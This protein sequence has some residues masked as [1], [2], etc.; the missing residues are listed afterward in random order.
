MKRLCIVTPNHS[1]ASMG[2]AEYQID[3][4]L[5]VMTRT[6]ERDIYYL[7]HRVPLGLKANGYRIVQVGSSD[8]VGRFG[9][10]LD[11]A[12]LYR[13]LRRI[14]PDVIYQRV[15]CG[16][17]G[18]AAHYAR[19]SGAR[20]VWH[21][22]HDSDVMPRSEPTDA[23]N[24]IKRVFEK[25][26]VEYGIRHAHR[27][28]VQTERQAQLLNENFGRKAD[29]LI[30]NFH[31]QPRESVEKPEPLTVV[32]I[33]NIKRW[34]QPEAFIRLAQ[35][36]SDIKNVRFVMVGALD[37]EGRTWQNDLSHRLA[38]TPNL[39]YVGPK[40]QASVNALLARAHVFVNTSLAEGYPNTFIQAWLREVPVISLTANPDGILDREGIGVHAGTEERLSQAVRMLLDDRVLRDEY[41]KRARRYA[42]RQ[43]SESNAL[44]LARLIDSDELDSETRKPDLASG[45]SAATSNPA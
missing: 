25:R 9:F 45:R 5:D 37:G 13:A 20:L 23:R 30:R 40:N 27:I 44:Q 35:H 17:T 1:A 19:V 6:R 36:L 29:A 21:V 3:R 11:A 31:P 32:W 39:D 41:G 38:N 28:V 34:K 33:A 15:A 22:A 43:H 26:C 42:M 14:A 10:W 12:P 4:L 7:A 18:I 24:P 8:G 2:G 16:Y